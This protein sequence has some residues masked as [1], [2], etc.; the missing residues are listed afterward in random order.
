MLLEKEILRHH[1]SHATRGTELCGHDGRCSK[2][3]Q[4][5]PLVRS[6]E[7]RRGAPSNIAESWIRRENSQFEMYRFVPGYAEAL[8]YLCNPSGLEMSSS[9]CSM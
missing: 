5:V 2:G 9:P 7:V 8:A 1:R 6:A 3:E 4:E